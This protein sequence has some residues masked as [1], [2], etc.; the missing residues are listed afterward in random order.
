MGRAIPL[1]NETVDALRGLAALAV[2]IGHLCGPT[3]QPGLHGIVDAAAVTQYGSYGVTVFFVISGFIVPYA[4][5][6]AGYRIQRLP[7]F[8][9]RRVVRLEPPYLISIALIFLLGLAAAATPGFRGQP[10]EW[11]AVQVLSHAGYLTGFLGFRWFNV[12]YWTLAIEFQFYLLIA[13][14]FPLLISTRSL[15]Q[16]GSVAVCAAIPLLVPSIPPAENQTPAF[17]LLLLPP[18][19][20]GILTFKFLTGRVQSTWYWAAL[21][22]LVGLTAWRGGVA[23]AVAA[24]TTAAVIAAV[25]LPRFRPLAFLGTISYS[26]YLVH[27]PIGPK[28][29]NLANRLGSSLAFE[30]SV[31]LAAVVV[32]I[33]VAA[34]FYRFVERP[35][36]K[37]ASRIGYDAEPA[38]LQVAMSPA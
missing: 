3:G 36:L 32:C 21:A 38:S 37:L 14:I 23:M 27:L 29:I 19:A 35:A 5:D 2:C 6:R 22:A 24:G 18:F 1:R 16:I 11:S 4:M 33:G 7:Q 26:L 28:I 15:S 9:L 30:I 12:V 10:L 34:V 8:L 17:V 20:A 25:R 31:F 13:V